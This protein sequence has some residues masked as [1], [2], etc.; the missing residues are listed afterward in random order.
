MKD[1]LINRLKNSFFRGI[2]LTIWNDMHGIDEVV[3]AF[4]SPG[5]AC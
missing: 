2:N 4:F 3:N 5:G 1:N